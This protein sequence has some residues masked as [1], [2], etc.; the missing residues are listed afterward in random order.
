[1]KNFAIKYKIL[2]IFMCLNPLAYVLSFFGLSPEIK[3][4]IS[5][6]LLAL[7]LFSLYLLIKYRKEIFSIDIYK[8]VIENGAIDLEGFKKYLKEA[9]RSLD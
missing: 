4:C 3:L 2:I 1:M 9:G 6:I 7:Q 8:A 5:S